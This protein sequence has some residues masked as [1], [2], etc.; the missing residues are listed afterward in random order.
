MMWY[1]YKYDPLLKHEET[2]GELV[3]DIGADAVFV[4]TDVDD[5][6]RLAL[7]NFFE[8]DR[9][10]DKQERFLWFW[11]RRL[12]E[13]YP[14]YKDEVSMWA[15]RK[16]EKWFFDNFKTESHTH[17]GTFKLDEQTAAELKRA[18]DRAVA[19]VYSGAT[20]GKDHSESKGSGTRSDDTTG[21][22][23][24]SESTTGKERAFGFKYPE[25]NYQGGVIP[26]DIDNNPNV[27]FIDTQTDR[28]S[29]GSRNTTG[30]NSSSSTGTTTDTT[31]ADGTSEGTATHTN[32]ET[33]KE[34]TDQTDKGTRGQQT[35]TQW[36]E[37]IRRQGDNLN[38]LARDLIADIPNTDF[39]RAFTRRLKPCFQSSYLL[40]EYEEDL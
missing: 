39:F 34:A 26:Y 8:L 32:N 22:E 29:K 38:S 21:E 27:E 14:V 11:R 15:E 9:L 23:S 30:E 20:T 18:L 17:T 4:K 25:A 35:E 7:I 1:D 19:D 40:D 12:A 33:V 24:G 2:F 5:A 28:V 16:L 10:C 31:T 6:T 36:T 37:E 13:N 3:D